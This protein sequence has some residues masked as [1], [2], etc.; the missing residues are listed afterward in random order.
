[1]NQSGNRK[2]KLVEEGGQTVA[3]LLV[4][5]NPFTS[6]HCNRGNC[7]ICLFEGSKGLC[8]I[9]SITYSNTCLKCEER[10]IS[11]K[12]WGESS[13]SLYERSLTHLEEGSKGYKDS[14]IYAHIL[15]YH[16]SDKINL[17]ENF[18]FE[19]VGRINGAMKRQVEKWLLIK[20]S[21]AVL[22]NS[23]DM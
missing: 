22:M 16:K 3:D 6:P 18:K 8:Q 7:Q 20:N 14:H 1:M 15:K 19:V 17:Q 5:K 11:F 23:K 13:E 4:K 10:G 21:K 2:V 9:R 12:Y